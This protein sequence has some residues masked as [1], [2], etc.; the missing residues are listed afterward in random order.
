MASL[1]AC[2]ITASGGAFADGIYKWT[3]EDGNVHYGDRPSGAPTE[4]RL[5][6][7]YNRTSQS[8]VT[9]RVD[10]YRDAAAARTKAKEESA[11]AAA[12]AAEE[13]AQAEQ[14]KAKC[15]QLRTKL[16]AMLNARR[17]YNED[18]NGEREWLDDEAREAARAKAQAQI[19]EHCS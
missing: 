10:A 16:T 9:R 7:S 4:E 15:E 13:K 8:D 12:T 14:L 17:V 6:M 5:Q 18:E 19:E 3:D 1:A 11:A 2:A